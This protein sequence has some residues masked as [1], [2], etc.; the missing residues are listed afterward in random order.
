MYLTSVR[1]KARSTHI[2]KETKEAPSE[3]PI[4]LDHPEIC[5]MFSADPPRVEASVWQKVLIILLIASRQ[6]LQ[7]NTYISLAWGFGGLSSLFV[8]VGKI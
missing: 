7:V 3:I 2:R 8:V 4:A 6:K 5:Q 1:A